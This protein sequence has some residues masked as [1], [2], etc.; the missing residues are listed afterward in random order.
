MILKTL[1]FVQFE[2]TFIYDTS[3]IGF[4]CWLLRKMSSPSENRAN[5]IM[6]DNILLFMSFMAIKK[7]VAE[8][9]VLCCIP[10]CHENVFGMM[11]FT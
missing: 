7:S 10:L 8:I 2:M 9:L 1:L 6:L 11:I 5:F 4:D 3:S